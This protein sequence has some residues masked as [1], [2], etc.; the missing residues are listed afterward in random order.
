MIERWLK[1]LQD[2]RAGIA[3]KP[4]PPAGPDPQSAARN[5]ELL[6]QGNAALAAGDLA[7]A[8]ERYRAAITAAPRN[9]AGHLNLGYVLLELGDPAQAQASLQEAASLGEGAD[10][11]Y[12]LGQT[13]AA[14]GQWDAARASYREA[15]SLRPDFGFAWRDLAVAWEHLGDLP[16]ALD[17]YERAVR[18][19][20]ELL[21]AVAACA[22]LQIGAGRFADALAT[23]RR[24]ATAEPRE[25]AAPFIEGQA[26]HAL[27]REDE[28]LA[29][30]DRAGA[31]APGNAAVLHTRGNVL[32]ALGRF[33]E[34]RICYTQ[35]RAAAP[36]WIEPQVN[37]GVVLDRMA[38]YE[39]ALTCFREVLARQPDH[40]LALYHLPILLVSLGRVPE[41]LEAVARA[42]ALHPHDADMEWHYAF[43]HL[44]AGRM[45]EGWPAYEARWKAASTGA[46][47][48]RHLFAQPLWTGQPLA[49]KTLLLYPEQGLGDILQFIRFVPV[50]ESRGARVLVWVPSSLQSLVAT[51]S[52][53]AL[54]SSRLEDLPQGDF[55]CPIMSVP[56]ALGTT[57][58]T[59]PS[60][61]P[62]LH[63]NA[64]LRRQWAD[65]LGERRGPRVGVVW[66]GNAAQQNDR[67]RSMPLSTFAGIAVPGC[68]Y[69]ALQNVVRPQDQ[70]AMQAWSDL[71]FF[72]DELQTFE[73]T[74]ALA[75]QM[76]LVVSVCTSG[77][78]LAGALGLPLWVLLA[79]RA[80]WRWLLDREDSP[81]YPTARLYRQSTSGDWPSVIS[82][83]R[84]DLSAL[85]KSRV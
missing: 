43:T 35:A 27:K 81:W 79:Y 42:R 60:S 50:L 37:L 28:A 71:R 68:E 75:S 80:D 70:A 76:D 33:E 30:L 41:A 13:Q 64:D 72:G 21:D 4:V 29:A 55:Q 85:G 40:K 2:R 49:G 3:A 53:E 15:L 1:K 9:P 67:H 16:T 61:V 65:K 36:E 58:D 45:Q 78:H 54:V 12:M 63:S 51:V 77:A 14:Q 7:A 46:A 66:S 32:F 17:A 73:D 8:A 82:R 23:A 56:L 6:Q 69:F 83:I 62:Y 47:L 26:L 5:A 84:A 39:E 24:W 19:A 57:L 20:P 38:C 74:A 10:A 59:L 18:H 44:L 22:R 48:S 52:S 34:A 25:W 31:L 11:L